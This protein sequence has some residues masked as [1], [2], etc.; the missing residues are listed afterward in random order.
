MSPQVAVITALYGRYDTVKPVLPQSRPFTE[1][2]L[3]TDREPDPEAAE[4]WRV[5]VE[6]RNGVSACRAAKLPKLR[7]WEYTGA[8][9]SVWL[10]ASFR[11]TSRW[12]VAQ[13]LEH[14]EPIAQFPH[15]ERDCLYAEADTVTVLGLDDPETVAQQ[16]AAYRR[17]GHPRNW[18]LWASGVIVRQHTPAVKRF[19]RMWSDSVE[20]WSHRDQLSEPYALRMAGLWPEALPGTYADND[21]LSYEGHMVPGG[22]P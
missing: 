3:V 9:A 11:V 14:A 8:S 17:A 19:G 16:T 22:S 12:F 18:G 2:V 20:I 5:V 4:G 7:P 6:P 21:W 13:A 1:W 10:D 15:P